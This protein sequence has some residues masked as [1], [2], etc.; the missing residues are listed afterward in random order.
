MQWTDETYTYKDGKVEEQSLHED[1]RLVNGKI[2][3]GY[4]Y[5]A[6]PPRKTEK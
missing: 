3:E 1:Y 5:K 2:R 6:S 4:Q